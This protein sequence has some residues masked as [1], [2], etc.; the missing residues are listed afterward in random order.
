[1]RTES[2]PNSNWKSAGERSAPPCSKSTLKARIFPSAS[3]TGESSRQSS[4]PAWISPV[5][6]SWPMAASI[7]GK[8]PS[9]KIH[10]TAVAASKAM[11]ACITKSRSNDPRANA[12]TPRGVMGSQA[13]A[14][15]VNALTPQRLTE[16]ERLMKFQN[17]TRLVLEN[18]IE[19]ADGDTAALNCF[20]RRRRL[21]WR[22]HH[23]D[24]QR[25][26][27]LHH[28]IHIDFDKISAGG[29]KL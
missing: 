3:S 29:L 10:T 25:I 14:G 27:Q 4:L 13:K 24:R 28:V 1:M 21:A 8:M 7:V 23:D 12:A 2:R 15:S 22:R 20:F 6:G 16:A 9:D 11:T 17:P 18:K 26:T 19:N 5:S